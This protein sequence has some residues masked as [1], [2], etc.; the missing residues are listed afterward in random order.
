M[1]ISLWYRLNC[2]IDY[3]LNLIYAV[4]TI[5]NRRLLLRRLQSKS[6]QPVV[7]FLVKFF[8]SVWSVSSDKADSLGVRLEF[9]KEGQHHRNKTADWSELSRIHYPSRILTPTK[10]CRLTEEA[11]SE[12]TRKF[13][14]TVNWKKYACSFIPGGDNVFSIILTNQRICFDNVVPLSWTR[15]ESQINRPYRRRW[16]SQR[17]NYRAN[18]MTCWVVYV[19]KV[20]SRNRKRYGLFT[21]NPLS[22]PRMH[23]Q[24]KICSTD[25]PSVPPIHLEFTIYFVISL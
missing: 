12:S 22:F 7:L 10:F 15:A 25:S 16:T 17:K 11:G 14:Y 9:M 18:K 13:C 5:Q 8:F 20:N 23:Y 21:R 24:F 2:V 3:F 19:Y 4:V 6:I 1:L